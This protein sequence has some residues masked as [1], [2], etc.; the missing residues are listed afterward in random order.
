M[1]HITDLY[2]YRVTWSDE[3]QE[4][5]GLCSEFPSLSWL[6][7][8]STDALLGIRNLVDECIVDM[9]ENNE[10]IPEALSTKKYSGKLMLRIAPEM[11]RALAVQAA[12]AG[13]SLNR[14]IA[15]RL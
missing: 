6:A 13:I 2:T 12:E 1:K 7:E 9:K 10:P 11:H 3:D 14:L 8:S 4:F 5:V 15:S